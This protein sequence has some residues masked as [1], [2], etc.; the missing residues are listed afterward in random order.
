M[1]IARFVSQAALFLGAALVIVPSSASAQDSQRVNPDRLLTVPAAGCS[2]ASWAQ[3][4][5]ADGASYPVVT[6]VDGGSPADRAGL[7][8]GD[9]ILEVNGKDARTLSSWFAATPGEEVSIRVL[10]NGKQREIFI[11]AGRPLDLAPEKLA[12]QCVQG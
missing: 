11:T 12:V 7:R 1:T 4:Q 2:G 3:F 5:T 6:Q 10:R 9:E 8:E